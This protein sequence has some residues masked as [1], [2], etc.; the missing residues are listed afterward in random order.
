[1]GGMLSRR[2]R[3]SMHWVKSCLRHCAAKACH[4]SI[5]DGQITAAAIYTDR[6]PSFK[7]VRRVMLRWYTWL[8]YIKLSL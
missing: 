2:S 7:M 3:V 8:N 1:M 4:P 5:H 6:A